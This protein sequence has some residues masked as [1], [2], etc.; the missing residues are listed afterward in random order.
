M[1]YINLSCMNALM[2]VFELCSV[3]CIVEGL[4]IIRSFEDCLG[5]LNYTLF[6]GLPRVIELYIVLWIAEG[7]WIIHNF[8]VL[9]N[10]DEFIFLSNTQYC[11][12]RFEWR[13][14]FLL[15]HMW[16]TN[17]SP[18]WCHLLD[19]CSS[20]IQNDLYIQGHPFF[21]HAPNI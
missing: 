2:K 15:F 8:C 18:G 7:H 16:P 21:R 10:W 11:F 17:L 13:G 9:S 1:L 19:R 6:C 5:L 4:W 20:S 3:L 14:D 12:W